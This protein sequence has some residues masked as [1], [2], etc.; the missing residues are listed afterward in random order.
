MEENN[1]AQVNKKHQVYLVKK[2]FFT[3]SHSHDGALNEMEHSHEFQYEVKIKGETNSE[4]YLADFRTIED[5]LN[6]KINRVFNYKSLNTFFRHP[7]TELLA[8][9]IYDTLKPF[10]QDK[11]HSVTLY[12]T[13]DSYII[14]EGISE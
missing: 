11:M 10:F 5:L 7:T 3:A 4:G 2:S 13:P 14:Y 9:H 12:E 8:V 6:T 1:T